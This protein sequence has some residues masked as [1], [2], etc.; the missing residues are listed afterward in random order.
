MILDICSNPTTL[1]IFKIIRIVITIIKIVVPII[2][3]ISLMI[4]LMNEVT[5]NNKDLKEASGLIVKKIGAA[6]LVFLIPTII[7][8]VSNTIG[9][10]SNNFISC[11]NNSTDENIEKMQIRYIDKLIEQSITNFNGSKYNNIKSEINKLKDDNLKN[12]YLN[13]IKKMQEEWKKNRKIEEDEFD[14]IN[15]PTTNTDASDIVKN[16]VNKALEI[17]ND[18]S[19]GYCNRPDCNQNP[20]FD[21]G[22]FVSFAL[23]SVGLLSEGEFMNPNDPNLAISTLCKY[24]FKM[25]PFDRNNLKYGDIVIRYGHTEIY[26][27]NGQS[28]GAHGNSA[29]DGYLVNGYQS[30]PY[31]QSGDQGDEI[32][33]GPLNDF[34]NIIRYEG[35]TVNLCN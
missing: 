6:V 3:M 13:K 14:H 25:Y 1:R 26:V 16:Y 34:T 12:E 21:C 31:T 10:N 30:G 9:F 7:S 22:T 11:I 20:D 2:L 28:V 32:S 29:A 8:I 23:R 18:N 4:T 19:H 27:D 24:G 35:Q 15:N 17:A 33:V 5:N